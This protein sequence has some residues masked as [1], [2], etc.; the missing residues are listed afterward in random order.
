[1][2]QKKFMKAQRQNRKEKTPNREEAIVP[3]IGNNI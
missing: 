2:K 1:M 3:Q